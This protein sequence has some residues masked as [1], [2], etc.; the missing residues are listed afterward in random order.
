MTQVMR[1]KRAAKAIFSAKAAEH[2]VYGAGIHPLAAAESH[3]T[4][5]AF[6]VPPFRNPGRI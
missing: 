1:R 5:S 2:L 3:D 4:N 6:V